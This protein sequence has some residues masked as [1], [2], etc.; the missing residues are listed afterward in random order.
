VKQ[1]L[2]VGAG[3][4][5]AVTAEAAAA[6]GRWKEILFLDDDSS[7]G[8]V[9]EYPVAGAVNQLFAL[10]EQNSEVIVAIGDN[11]KRLSL[12]NEITAKGLKL[13]TV[14]HPNAC[15]SPSATIL[16]GT[17]V[18]AGAIV[19]ARATLGRACILNTGATVDHDCVIEDGVHISPG[20]NLAGNVSVGECT[21]I[22]IGSAIK[23]GVKV[24][25][26]VVAGAGSAIISDVDDGETVGGVP[27]R[28]LNK[29]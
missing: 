16:P 10:A 26:D 27:A 29:Q 11:R 13:A 14:I 3:G 24:G 12:C 6:I 7:L 9:L 19:N 2:I 21:W 22:G 4:H 20:A 25:R 15:I 1:L 8:T 18:C 17:L 28:R 23:E 5:G